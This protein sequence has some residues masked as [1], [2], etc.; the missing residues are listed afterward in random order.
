MRY[1]IKLFTLLVLSLLATSAVAWK[2]ISKGDA[3]ACRKKNPDAAQA[4]ASFC[5]RFPMNVPGRDARIGRYSKNTQIVARIMGKCNPAEKVPK[6]W[7]F[8]QFYNMC[9][10]SKKKNATNLARYGGG[11]C[12]EWQLLRK[13]EN[14]PG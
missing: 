6:S 13:G 2:P 10:N 9:R 3:E 5:Q 11:G 14:V 7:C 12:Q 4:V 8:K 1:P